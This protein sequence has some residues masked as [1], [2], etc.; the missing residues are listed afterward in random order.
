VANR[1]LPA[2]VTDDVAALLY[3][4]AAAEVLSWPA[5]AARV[6]Q[7]TQVH[8]KL[9]PLVRGAGKHV[10]DAAVTQQPGPLDLVRQVA[11][12]VAP[13]DVFPTAA[14]FSEAVAYA[15]CRHEGHDGVG[16]LVTMRAYLDQAVVPEDQPA[17]VVDHAATREQ[18][19][20]VALLIQPHRLD[21]MR[22]AFETFR[23]A[24]AVVYSG[25]H[26]RHWQ[27]FRKLSRVVDSLTPVASAVE[28]LNSLRALG[29]PVS[30]DAIEDYRRLSSCRTVCPA[31]DLSA[32]LIKRP[33]CGYCG[34][35]LND[36]V[37]LDSLEDIAYRLNAA[38]AVQ[39]RR[40]ASEAVRR[41]LARGGA[42][43]DRFVEIV[44][45]TDTA[46]LAQILDDELVVFLQELLAQPVTPTPEA[47]QLFE[48]IALAH[49]VITEDQVDR[50]V[51]T[52]RMLLLEQLS[53]CSSDDGAPVPSFYLTPPS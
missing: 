27:S 18:L 42:R 11:A 14:A 37:P 6:V 2:A 48:Q 9:R 32:A 21:S 47:L 52:L 7:P 8:A 26:R 49:P 43:L 34:L 15:R 22:A 38:L 40:L 12:G 30:E 41:I 51:E 36:S 33:L 53:A 29:A 39:Q 31:D 5:P 35:A 28:R 13:C 10:S 44:Q 24:F 4:E 23:A 17:L 45:A 25:Y 20:F 50:V 3:W 46:S 19:S 16:E 1:S